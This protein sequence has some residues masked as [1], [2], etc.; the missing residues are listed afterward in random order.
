MIGN[1]DS[2]LEAAKEAAETAYLELRQQEQHLHSHLHNAIAFIFDS[3]SRYLLLRKDA[4]KELQAI[5]ESLRD[6]PLIGIYTYGEQAPLK[7][8]KYRGRTHFHN[9]TITIMIL[10]G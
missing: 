10:E 7:A 5:K 8:V 1:K 6:I 4:D 9:Q 3:S 2:C